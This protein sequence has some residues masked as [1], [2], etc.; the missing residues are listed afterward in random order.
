MEE[1]NTRINALR[2]PRSHRLPQ[3]LISN[4]IKYCR[5]G[6]PEIQISVDRQDG[7]F[8]FS[9]RDRGIGI[10]PEHH[11]KV[12][13]IFQ[14][15]HSREEFRGTGIGLAISRKIVERHGGRIWVESEPGRG[16][17]FFFTLPAA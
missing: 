13:Y 16:A 1:F 5:A 7:E 9:A 15:L 8:R 3:N 10:A 6:M 12:F 2:H 11:E 17:V 14:M 4:S